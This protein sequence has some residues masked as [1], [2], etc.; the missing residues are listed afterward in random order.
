MFDFN[1]YFALLAISGARYYF[2]AKLSLQHRARDLRSPRLGSVTGGQT[3][4]GRTG[5]PLNSED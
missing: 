1:G 2:G 3:V 5:A 4:P